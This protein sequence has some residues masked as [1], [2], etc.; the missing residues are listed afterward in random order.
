LTYLS[1]HAK[2]VAP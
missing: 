2:S 1:C